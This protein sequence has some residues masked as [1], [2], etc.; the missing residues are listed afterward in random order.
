MRY[1]LFTSNHYGTETRKV[2]TKFLVIFLKMNTI[3]V[4]NYVTNIHLRYGNRTPGF[5][6]GTAEYNGVMELLFT[7]ESGKYFGF[8]VGCGKL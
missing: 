1:T 5:R 4:L 2:K 7:A 3:R 6:W 8:R